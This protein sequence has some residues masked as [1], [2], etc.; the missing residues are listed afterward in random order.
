MR[1]IWILTLD[2][3]YGSLCVAVVEGVGMFNYAYINEKNVL[4]NLPAG[5]D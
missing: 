4:D 3:C 1:N 2:Q 5:Q